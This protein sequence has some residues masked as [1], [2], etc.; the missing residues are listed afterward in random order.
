MKKVI[1]IAV[2]LCALAACNKEVISAPS[3][4]VGYLSFGLSADDVIVE[5]KAAVTDFTG[6]KVHVGESSYDY[7]S[8]SSGMV[9]PLAPG[10]YNIYAEN[11]SPSAAEEGNGALRLASASQNVTIVSGETISRT[12]HCE[13]TNAKI[14]VEF[15]ESFKKAFS[16][17]TLEIDYKDLVQ[18]FRKKRITSTTA[19]DD[20]KFF[21]NIY[22]D[23]PEIGLSLSA[24]NA[25]STTIENFK[26]FTLEAKKRYVVK[27]SAGANGYLNVQVTANNDLTSVNKDYTVNPYAPVNQ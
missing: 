5:T 20:T 21:Y 17:Y 11:I 13:A 7:Q 27:Y 12:L 2:A 1:F 26:Y 24:Q 25:A 23:K 3:S 4:E 14:E 8:V 9:L 22:S 10:T 19:V 16:S 18:P 15:D 6:Y